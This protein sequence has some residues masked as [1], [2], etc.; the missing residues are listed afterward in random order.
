MLHLSKSVLWIFALFIIG[1][2]A[3]TIETARPVKSNVLVIASDFLHEKDTLLFKQFTQKNDVRLIIRHLS[4][5]QMASEIESKGY[6]SGIDLI[7]SN[8][9]QTPIRL[10]KHGILQ[11]LVEIESGVKGQNHYISYK[12]NFVGIGLDPFVFKYTSDTILEP[13]QY[14]DL[15][16]TTH[17]HTL[18]TADIV[19]FLSPMRRKMNRANTYDWAKKWTE[20]SSLRPEKGPWHDSAQV[21][22]CKYSQLEFFNDSVWKGY[23][24]N[25]YF[26]NEDKGGV[27]FDLISLS[28]VQQAEHFSDAQKFMDYCQNSGHNSTLNK[29]LNCF[30][31]YDYL[32]TR[33]NGP[34]FYSTHIDQLLKY[35][36]V[37]ERMLDKLN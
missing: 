29:K 11:D 9:M 19:S 6:N 33:I 5:D 27:Y 24:E 25:C 18:S 7:F 32:E 10:N 35:H 20:N 28:I 14:Q 16:N 26:P 30:P 23:S 34:K 17:Y 31:I 4:T 15:N 8:N 12:H 36:D 2:G 21:V 3:C 1:I 13:R 22:L 37:L